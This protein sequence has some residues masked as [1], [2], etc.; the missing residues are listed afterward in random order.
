[1]IDCSL[2]ED[3]SLAETLIIP[4]ASISNVTSICGVP[5]G[6]DGISVKLN[7]PKDLLSGTFFFPLEE[8]E[9]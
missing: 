1:M 5:R 2:F 9:Q 7:W 6:A 3:L 8:H 4:L